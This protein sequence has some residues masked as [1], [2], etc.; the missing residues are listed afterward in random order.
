MHKIEQYITISQF[1]IQEINTFNNV[2]RRLMYE[3]HKQ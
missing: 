2:S 3:I 1:Q